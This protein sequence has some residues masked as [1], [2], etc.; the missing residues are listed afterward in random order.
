MQLLLYQNYTCIAHDDSSVGACTSSGY[1]SIF[2]FTYNAA[3][4]H[5]EEIKLILR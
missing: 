4:I 5:G 1:S 2:L 3:I